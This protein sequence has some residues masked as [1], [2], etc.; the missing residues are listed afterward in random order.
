MLIVQRELNNH[1]VTK[2]KLTIPPEDTIEGNYLHASHKTA[3]KYQ[4]KQEQVGDDVKLQ[5]MDDENIT[6]DGIK[7]QTCD[8]DGEKTYFTGMQT[9]HTCFAG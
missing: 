6:N 9:F 7:F 8:L 3:K 5:S 2:D 1:P 4:I